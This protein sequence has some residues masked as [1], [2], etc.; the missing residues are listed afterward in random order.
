MVLMLRFYTLLILALATPV[1]A[2]AETVGVFFD[3]KEAQIKFAATDVKTALESKGF[4]VEMLSLS[5]LKSGYGKKKVVIALASNSEVSKLL[6]GE[7]ATMPSG[8]GEQ[9]YALRTTGK[10]NKSYW[11]FGGDVNGAM[12]GGFQVAEN[13]K[14]N[15]F[16]GTYNQEESPNILKR[17]VKLNLPFDVNSTT[18]FSSNKSTSSKNAITHVWD[19]SFWT[20][21]FDEMARNRYNVVSVWNN[22]C[23]TSMI[24]MADYP[25]VVLNDV[26]GY[27]DIYND[28]DRKGKVIKTMTIDQKIEFWRNVMAYAKSRGFT[29][30]LFNWN[31]FLESATG[32]YGL[33]S[34]GE[35]VTNPAT[36]TYVRKCTYELL[37]T[38]PDLDGIGVTQ[39]EGMIPKNDSLNSHFL[40]ITYG[41]GMADFAKEHPNR[42]LNFIHRWHMADFKSIQKNF[43]ELL[44]CPNVTFDMSFKYSAAHMYSSTKPDFMTEKEMNFLKKNKV[45]SWL[46]VRNDDFYYHNWGSPEY[47]REYLKNI[48]GQGDWFKG[49]YIGADGFNPTRTFFSKN[50][51]TQ[52]TLEV[53]RQWYMNMIWGRLAYNPNT[54]DDVFKNHMKLKYP[55]VSSNDLFAAWSK[56]SKAL[57]KVGELTLNAFKLDFHWYPEH[58]SSEKGF[59][60][61]KHFAEAAPRKSSDFCSI[62][63][64]AANNC[65]KKTSAYAVAD[66]IEAD[67]LSTLSLINAMTAPDN[68][69]LG[70]TLNTIKSMSYLTIY[71][72]YKI[73]GATYNKAN[74][75]T[76][77]KEAMG[78]AYCWWMKYTNLMDAN[79]KGMSCQRTADFATWHHYDAEVLKEYTELGGVGT[80]NCNK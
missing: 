70:V 33:T 4:Q 34:G 46:T 7:A 32:K 36:A 6:T 74:K 49:F 12:Y 26:T 42:K 47:A 64:S 5:A 35:G 53:Q 77:A 23:F 41:K 28:K 72:A 10:P 31:L 54:S 68:S 45:K 39:G 66:Q 79:Y 14:F 51:I 73:R 21:W 52:N 78:T 19:M 25:D 59:L 27:P 58:C 11:V 61:I 29:F 18:Y 75:T 55:S 76:E 63:G 57:P 17:G 9:A 3:S 15:D 1:L 56:V 62:E 16:S 30:Y 67:A 44:Q 2:F 60:T 37:K 50:S 48:P 13:I 8:L 20:T 22:H 69:E 80:P 71:Y 24:K 65:D 43:A 38:Y 40:G